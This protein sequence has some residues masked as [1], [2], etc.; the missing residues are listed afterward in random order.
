M[1]PG[2]KAAVNRK[3]LSSKSRLGSSKFIATFVDAEQE[4]V[5]TETLVEKEAES[6]EQQAL[7]GEENESAKE[8]DKDT[9]IRTEKVQEVTP[10]LLKSVTLGIRHSNVNIA[11][12]LRQ[13]AFTADAY[14][15]SKRKRDDDSQDCNTESPSK[16]LS[17][18]AKI[19]KEKTFL[20][21][22][23]FHHQSWFDRSLVNLRKNL[24]GRNETFF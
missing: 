1:T 22:A 10:L 15:S 3:K 7:A 19:E 11:S 17:K 4:A 18:R 8:N 13:I 14:E 12:P 5:V 16:K 20:F 24:F 6:K 23:P 2:R 21:S 9:S